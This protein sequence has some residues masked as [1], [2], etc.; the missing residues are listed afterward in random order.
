MELVHERQIPAMTVS[1]LF[2]FLVITGSYGFSHLFLPTQASV[3]LFYWMMDR[4]AGLVAYELLAFSVLLGL[5]TANSFWDRL[6]LRRVVTQLHQFSALLTACFVAL[7]LWGLHFDQQIPFPWRN[8]FIPLAST[9][10]PLPTALGVLTLYG[11]IAITISSILRERIGV[12]AWRAIHFAYIP[13]FLLVTFHGILSGT[14][15][16]QPWAIWVYAVPFFLFIVLLYIRMG[17]LKSTLAARVGGGTA[18]RNR[19]DTQDAVSTGEQNSVPT[20]AAR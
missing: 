8:F 12:K 17:K 10:R 2:L 18:A 11:L 13:M 20:K 4:S 15:S 6:R 16:T 9:Y 19:T 3:N 7:H 1:G 14:D 5:T